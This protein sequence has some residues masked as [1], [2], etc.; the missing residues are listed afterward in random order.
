M[1][2]SIWIQAPRIRRCGRGYSAEGPGFF[3]WDPDPTA[4][5]N[6]AILLARGAVPARMPER[7]LV[8]D[9]ARGVGSADPE[10]LDA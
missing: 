4:V 10:A 3:V 7:L 1:R 8:L 2:E 9:G 6:A 5:A